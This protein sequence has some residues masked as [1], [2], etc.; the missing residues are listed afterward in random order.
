MQSFTAIYEYTEDDWWVVSVPEIPGAYSQG[1]T[2]EEAR[3][4][5]QDAVR[6]LLE[7]RRE[8]VNRL[9]KRRPAI[10]PLAESASRRT[11]SGIPSLFKVYA[12]PLSRCW[13]I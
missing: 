10:V 6:L 7:I 12:T 5:I 4:K 9:K 13:L 2:F 3:E 1:L 11:M 8:E